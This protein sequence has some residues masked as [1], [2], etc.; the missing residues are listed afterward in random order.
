H[1][2]GASGPMDRGAFQQA[3]CGGRGGIE[4]TRAGIEFRV[5]SGEC[6]IG[7]AGGAFTVTINGAL[8]H[9]PGTARLGAGGVVSI[10][11][12]AWGNY[13]SLRFDTDLMAEAIMGS[14]ATSS[15]A[16]LVGVNG[17]PLQV[18]DVLELAE[19][20]TAPKCAGSTHTAEGPLR[21]VWGLHA[22]LF[23]PLQRQ[24]F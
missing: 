21:I 9:W 22:D 7:F 5:A 1:G 4:L 2:I 24:K 3:G 19:Q 14:I 23:E 10:T 8:A 13:G 12:G 17:R 6:Q 18:G 16:R 15:R 11:P 20:G